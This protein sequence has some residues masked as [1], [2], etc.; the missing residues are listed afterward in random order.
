MSSRKASNQ[1]RARALCGSMRAGSR[2]G[3][4][5]AASGAAFGSGE[6]GGAELDHSFMPDRPFDT[7]FPPQNGTGGTRM[8]D[9]DGD[10][11]GFPTASVVQIFALTAPLFLLSSRV[12]GS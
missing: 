9:L 4:A 8:H 7:Y 2:R 6:G 10:G 12:F 11:T 5:A 1:A 3:G